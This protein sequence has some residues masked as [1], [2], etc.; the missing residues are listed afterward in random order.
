M[1]STGCLVLFG[2][3]QFL[4]I[5]LVEETSAVQPSDAA[6]SSLGIQPSSSIMESGTSRL[7]SSSVVMKGPSSSQV[8]SSSAVMPGDA[9]AT[10]EIS[11]TKTV[12]PSSDDQFKE[13]VSSIMGSSFV[14]PP[15]ASENVSQATVLP[16]LPVV[17]S[18]LLDAATPSLEEASQSVTVLAVE[19][20]SSTIASGSI[21]SAA[22][23]VIFNSSVMEVSGSNSTVVPDDVGS[24]SATPSE[25][26]LTTLSMDLTMEPMQASSTLSPSPASSDLVVPTASLTTSAE[27]T[28]D[29][30]KN[31]DD[32]GM[33]SGGKVAVAVIVSLCLVALIIAGV[34]CYRKHSFT[35]RSLKEFLTS[36][37]RYKTYNNASYKDDEGS[38]IM[39]DRR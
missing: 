9:G 39:P 15:L 33:P 16:D 34:V 3:L 6:H 21:F 12:F 17:P 23:E 31:D 2:L 5:G 20:T 14:A 30:S 24:L 13:S 10:V 27:P 4:A 36:S 11:P 7:D 26:V 35:H 1:K 29:K 22:S 32:G 19:P 18:S 37:V 38:L 28:A 25:S 8:A